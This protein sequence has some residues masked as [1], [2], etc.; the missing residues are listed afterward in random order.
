NCVDFW[1]KHKYDYPS[2]L[3]N[4][5]QYQKDAINYI[6]NAQL[7]R[8][9][10]DNYQ[11]EYVKAYDRF[12]EAISLEIIASKKEGRALQIYND[13]PVHYA[14]QFDDDIEKDLFN[15]K[16]AVV[17]APVKPPEKKEE[18]KVI[19]ETST[20]VVTAVPG[21]PEV[22]QPN[23]IYFSVQIAAHTVPISDKNLRETIYKG[24][25]KITEMREAGWF[26]YLL[27]HFTNYYDACGC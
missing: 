13:W 10:A 23:V 27:G 15:P 11:H 20:P 22:L 3:D 9:V 19:P 8:R 5:R 25:M 21:E 17:T 2:G 4:A 7:N 6:K 26:K 16:V 24:P 18:A 12:F 14:Y 1:N